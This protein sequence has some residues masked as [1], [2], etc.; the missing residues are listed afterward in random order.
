[1]LT[2]SDINSSHEKLSGKA[3]QNWCL[4][5]MTV[6]DTIDQGQDS[7]PSGQRFLANGVV[8]QTNCKDD[9]APK[10]TI[11]QISYSKVFIEEYKQRR[12]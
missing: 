11:V 4:R 7:Q 1:M 9:C 8:I 3:A 10:I 5:R 12:N 6:I 2:P